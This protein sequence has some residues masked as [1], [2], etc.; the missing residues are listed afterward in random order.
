MILFLDYSCI[1]LT[2]FLQSLS[3]YSSIIP[4]LLF[5]YF[6][7]NSS[8]IVVR[9]LLVLFLDALEGTSKGEL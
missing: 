2:L 5:Y 6:K 3:Y 9:I 1:I 4:L 7:N 8:I